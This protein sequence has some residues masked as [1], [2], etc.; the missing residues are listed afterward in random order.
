MVAFFVEDISLRSGTQEPPHRQTQFR[1]Q[2]KHETNYF[3]KSHDVIMQHMHRSTTSKD[4]TRF[5]PGFDID[6]FL[7]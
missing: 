4:E 1:L 2:M 6:I 7:L 3:L 5:D